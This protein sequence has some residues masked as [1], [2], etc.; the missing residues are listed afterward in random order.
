MLSVSNEERIIMAQMQK[1]LDLIESKLN[2][3]LDG[4]KNNLLTERNSVP[5]LDPEDCRFL[6]EARQE[7][8]SKYDAT[9]NYPRSFR[10]SIN[11]AE[12]YST[13]S[14]RIFKS[15]TKNNNVW[16]SARSMKH[17]QDA[18]AT[19]EESNTVSSQHGGMVRTNLVFQ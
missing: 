14:D 4:K 15:H 1:K 5:M 19:E 9:S 16:D 2:Y 11:G 12:G 18:Y 3:F 13:T 6:E 17:K 10:S 8:Y 7:I